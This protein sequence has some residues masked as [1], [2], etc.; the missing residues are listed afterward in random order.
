VAYLHLSGADLNA[1][2]ALSMASQD[3]RLAA[4]LFAIQGG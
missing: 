3:E 4:V 1:R 2:M